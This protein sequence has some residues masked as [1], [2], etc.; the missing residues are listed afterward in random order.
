[1][2]SAR[3][4]CVMR[5]LQEPLALFSPD[6]IA[7]RRP[8]RTAVNRIPHAGVAERARTCTLPGDADQTNCNSKAFSTARVRSRT[9]SLDRMLET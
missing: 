6:Y 2:R 7:W 3:R 1:M 5:L 4:V 9:P 8:D